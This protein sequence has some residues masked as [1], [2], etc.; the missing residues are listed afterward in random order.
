MVA[1]A[2]A[3]QGKAFPFRSLSLGARYAHGA[4]K[5]YL[6]RECGIDAMALVEAAQEM[7][8]I[9]LGVRAKDLQMV[10]IEPVHSM[11]KAEAL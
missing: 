11:A 3:S 2:M 4:S 7:V 6:M 9:R 1:E 8:G 5:A 10:R